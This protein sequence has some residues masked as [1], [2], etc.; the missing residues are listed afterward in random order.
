MST[1]DLSQHTP[2]LFDAA[3]PPEAVKE[4]VNE[5]KGTGDP[6]KDF[7]RWCFSLGSDFRNSPDI[8]N[9]RFWAKNSKLKLK[10]A[11][12]DRLLE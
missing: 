12:E 1:H 6:S 9:L 4:A 10:P 2:S 11:D 7:V 3:P 8:T 5:D